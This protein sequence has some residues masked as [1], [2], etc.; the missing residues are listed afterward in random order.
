MRRWQ[1]RPDWKYR[2]GKTGYSPFR[3][4]LQILA[5]KVVSYRHPSRLEV[6]ASYTRYKRGQQAINFNYLEERRIGIAKPFVTKTFA[7]YSRLML[8]QILLPGTRY[9]T[10]EGMF[11]GAVGGIGANFSTFA[12]FAKGQQPYPYVYSNFSVSVPVPSQRMLIVPQVQYEYNSQRVISA[13]CGISR[14]LFYR[15]YLSCFCEQNFLSD[16]NNVGISLRYDLSFGQ[17][18][19]SALRG[20]TGTTLVQAARGGFIY[21]GNTDYFAA[22][23]RVNTGTG[24]IVLLPFLDMNGNGKK[25]AGEIKV[26]GIKVSI[27]TGRVITNDRD[28]TVRILELEPYTSYFVDLS[29]SNFDNIAWKLAWQTMYVTIDPHRLKPIAVPVS[30]VGEVSGKVYLQDKEERREMGRISVCIYREDGGMVA[31]TLTPV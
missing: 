27:N 29:R 11:S 28:T 12:L 16:I 23:N 24:G 22:N 14:Y 8:N 13:K 4:L 30:V 9:T 18:A 25:D 19:F 6:E 21:D 17:V 26:P 20:N 31:Q 1:R 7:V 10:L 15:G 3:P 5:L 2:E